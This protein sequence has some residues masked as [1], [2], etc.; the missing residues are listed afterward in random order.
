M[1]AKNFW[2]EIILITLFSQKVL[3][4]HIR[5]K[6]LPSYQMESMG[7]FQLVVGALIGT[8]YLLGQ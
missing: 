5:C 3:L 4:S 6:H 1:K 8:V 7:S 2:D